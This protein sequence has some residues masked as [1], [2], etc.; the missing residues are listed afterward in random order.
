[1]DTYQIFIY[2][3]LLD[4]LTT[5]IGFKLGAA[6]ASPFI[7]LLM[8]AGPAAGVIA[9]KVLALGIGGLCVYTHK[10]H[11]IRWISY[12]YGGL[13]VWNLMVMLAAPGHLGA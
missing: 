10:P 6:E 9:S 12:W 2:L 11:V 5:L 1:M 8:H 3:Q 4:L 13:V 7:Q